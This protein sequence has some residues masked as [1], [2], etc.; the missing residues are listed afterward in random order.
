MEWGGCSVRSRLWFPTVLAAGPVNRIF[1]HLPR[2]QQRVPDTIAMVASNRPLPVVAI[3]ESQRLRVNL[4]ASM[5][6]IAHGAGKA[7]GFL[8]VEPIQVL[9]LIAYL[10]VIRHRRIGFHR[11]LRLKRFDS[12]T[13]HLSK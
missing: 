8:V 1:R 2:L 9:R 7:I 11:F 5:L 3:Q 4:V 6:F 10:S 13:E 12:V